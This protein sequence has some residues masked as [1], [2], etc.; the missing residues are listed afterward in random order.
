MDG[1]LKAHKQYR[2]TCIPTLI[3]PSDGAM[4]LTRNSSLPPSAT[5][6]YD[7]RYFVLSE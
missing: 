3:F 7:A 4:N 5:T 6:E 1:I 2:M